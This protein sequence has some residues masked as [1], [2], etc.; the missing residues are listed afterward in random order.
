MYLLEEKSIFFN[1]FLIRQNDVLTACDYEFRNFTEQK[2]HFHYGF[3][4]N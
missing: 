4:N 2:F 3:K 1:K